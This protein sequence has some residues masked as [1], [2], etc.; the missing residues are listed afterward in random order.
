ML[1]YSSL[2]KNRQTLSEV[3]IK[4]WET[5]WD[6]NQEYTY[7]NS[8]FFSK[9][10][11]WRTHLKSTW[12][13]PIGPPGPSFTVSQ[14]CHG[15][16]SQRGYVPWAVWSGSQIC[17]LWSNITALKRSQRQIGCHAPTHK[18]RA[19]TFLLALRAAAQRALA[20]KQRFSA[21]FPDLSLI[22][23][24]TEKTWIN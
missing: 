18:T 22:H 10:R 20:T 21:N 12:R 19:V 9:S 24:R 1:L 2:R 17:A 23:G 13:G 4:S 3:K 15:D 5:Q 14:S 6:K 16:P 8:V 11:A 7:I